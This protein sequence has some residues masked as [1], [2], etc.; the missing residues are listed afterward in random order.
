[1]TRFVSRAPRKRPKS[2]VLIF[3]N[4][5]IGF[6]T[7]LVIIT[8]IG[9]FGSYRDNY[10]NRKFGDGYEHYYIEREDYAGLIYDYVNDGGVIGNINPGNEDVA[11]VAE[12]ADA[13]FRFSA[14]EK[15]G[16]SERA[17][18]QKE[19]MEKAAAAMGIYEPEKAKIDSQLE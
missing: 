1:M 2:K 4:V 10:Y 16:D 11:A 14:Y 5:I 7:A 18:R 17:A 9:L 15:A 6:L 12:Y 13:A 8:A 3:L 19:R